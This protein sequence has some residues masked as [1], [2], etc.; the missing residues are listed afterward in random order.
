MTKGLT[1]AATQARD[2]LRWAESLRRKQENGRRKFTADEEAEL[3]ALA[4]GTLRKEANEATLAS[5]WG[6]I[7]NDDGSYEDIAQHG[8]G[9]VRT[10]LGHVVPTE[11]DDDDAESM[12]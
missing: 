8:G 4:A 1:R 5:G 10:L 12:D 9:I 11:A 2:R 3:R 6:R 7:K